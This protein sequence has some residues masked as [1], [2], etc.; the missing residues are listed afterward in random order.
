MKSVL[1]VAMVCIVAVLANVS[2]ATVLLTDDFNGSSLNTSVWKTDSVAPAIS[3]SDSKVTMTPGGWVWLESVNSFAP[4]AG[5]T[6]T[7]STTNCQGSDWA[8]GKAWGFKNIMIDCAG[9]ALSGYS[10][11]IFIYMNA[12]GFF[13]GNSQYLRISNGNWWTGDFTINWSAEKV[14]V[15]WYD[16][17]IFDS[18]VNAPD[19]RYGL[20]TST[21]NIPT[22]AAPIFASTYCGGANMVFN[23]MTLTSV[24]EPAMLSVLALGV[25]GLIRRKK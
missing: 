19:S 5:E 21:W 16:S 24:P 10:G 1:S 4:A 6:L 13:D 20:G 22:Q 3:V 8:N 7:L 14:T 25:L 11:D 12:T 9:D 17:V 15:K 2:S 23:N 18:T